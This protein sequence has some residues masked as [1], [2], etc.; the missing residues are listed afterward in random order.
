MLVLGLLDPDADL[1]VPGWWPMVWLRQ[2]RPEAF[3][4]LQPLQ[5]QACSVVVLLLLYVVVLLSFLMPALISLLMS[6][7][8]AVAS[9]V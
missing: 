3:I 2:Q 9:T 8:R 5:E 7:A 6:S 1:L 4:L